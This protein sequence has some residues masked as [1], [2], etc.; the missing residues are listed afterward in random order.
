MNVLR[1]ILNALASF[2][3]VSTYIIGALF[4]A[5][6]FWI[7][8][9]FN[10]PPELA[11]VA[12]L[13]ITMG[14]VIGASFLTARIHRWIGPPGSDAETGTVFRESIKRYALVATPLAS[15]Y[16]IAQIVRTVAEVIVQAP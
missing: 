13:V 14:S 16:G 1:H 10:P 9:Q 8:L 3:A 11:L 7:S 6:L 12:V 15:G 4:V 2:V 5:T